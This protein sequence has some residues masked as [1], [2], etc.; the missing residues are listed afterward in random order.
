MFVLG[1]DIGYSNLKMAYG[2]ADAEKP[3]VKIAAVGAAP[4]ELLPQQI[5]GEASA[6]ALRVMVDGEPWVAGVEPERLQ[7]W[8]RELH[9]DY[10]ATKA[11][12]ALFYAALLMTEQDTI[13]VLVTGLPVSQQQDPA[14]RQALIDRM[15]GTH[16]ITPKRSVTVKEVVVIAQPAG[17]YLDCLYSGQFDDQLDLFNEGRAV[18][19]DPGFFSVDWVALEQGEVRSHSSGTSLKAMSMLLEEANDAIHADHGAAPGVDKIERAVRAGRNEVLLL[20]KKV[21]IQEYLDT[22]AKR[23]A[24]NALV[25]LRRSMREDGMAV[26]VVILAGGGAAHYKEAAAKVFPDS[27]VAVSSDPV[28]ANARGFW[29]Y[30]V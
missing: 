27:I 24:E 12:K 5:T 6:N 1:L 16:H 11:Y 22:A 21:P 15:T 17:A 28:L 14:A 29:H 13:D 25:P 4:I 10:P 18:V 7:G 20:G 26:D 2:F 30:G 3:T 8:D 9:P 19:I 23:V